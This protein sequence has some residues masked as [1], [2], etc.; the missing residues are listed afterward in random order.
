MTAAQDKSLVTSDDAVK[1]A[2]E[3][4]REPYGDYRLHR[5]DVVQIFP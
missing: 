2:N 1:N 4:Q 3:I 5:W